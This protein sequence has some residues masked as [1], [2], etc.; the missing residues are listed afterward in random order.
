[1]TRHSDL[2]EDAIDLEC[3]Q[4]TVKG[5]HEWTTEH[6]TAGKESSIESRSYIIH[7]PRR[8]WMG[9]KDK[10]GRR[11]RDRDAEM[12]CEKYWKE[13]LLGCAGGGTSRRNFKYERELDGRGE[14]KGRNISSEPRRCLS[15]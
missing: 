6:M 12:D 15:H 8:S 1:M 4:G 3:L 14:I 2:I 13:S 7:S 11:D 5:L 10:G 9:R